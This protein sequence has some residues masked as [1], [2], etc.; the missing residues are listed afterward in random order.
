MIC[1]NAPRFFSLKPLPPDVHLWVDRQG[2]LPGLP[3]DF[4]TDLFDAT[5]RRYFIY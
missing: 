4:G 5:A 2:H 3:D 1:Y